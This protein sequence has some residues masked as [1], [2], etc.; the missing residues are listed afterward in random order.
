[1]GYKK[2]FCFQISSAL[3][4]YKATRTPS[5]TLFIK[6][7]RMNMPVDS[8]IIIG[9]SFFLTF[10][11]I[12]VFRAVSTK[13]NILLCKGV[14]LIGGIAFGIA[15]ALAAFAGLFMQHCLSQES[16]AIII[17]S[18]VML[19]FG[20]MDDIFEFSVISK[21]AVQ[22][23]AAFFL[24]LCGVK[25]QIVYLGFAANVVVTIFWV[26]AVTNAVNH[27]DIMDGLAGCVSFFMGAAFLVIALLHHDADTAVVC[28]ALIGSV[29]GF[30]AFNLPPARGY[31]G[32]AGSHFL[33]FLFA[34]IALTLHYATL[35]NKIA[36]LSP[37]LIIGMP[38]FDT[39]FLI[40]MRLQ[41]SR[42][43]FRKSNDHLAFRFLKNGYS[44]KKTLF[45]MSGFALFCSGSG[46]LTVH[47]P[48]Y[49]AIGTIA[50][51]ALIGGWMVIAMGR[52]AI[53][54]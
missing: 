27:L 26:L 46:V 24:V 21:F 9:G 51:V 36:L 12:L 42:S 38:I 43:I 7:Q 50:A 28:A 54:G 1:L 6:H 49:L 20:I 33:G 31:M 2:R 8:P 10:F 5:A 37:L 4:P 17:A 30:L 53:D 3:L 23:I 25:T 45:L 16:L 11:L 18:T 14:P 40:V 13:N 48:L 41:K 35:E 47:A 22:L 32:N 15:F 44:K 39:A 52:V 34:S 19:G 29:A